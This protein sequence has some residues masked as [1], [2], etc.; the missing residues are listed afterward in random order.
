M[1]TSSQVVVKSNRMIEASYRLSL[2]EQQIIL[3]AICKAREDQK[4]LDSKEP[5]TISANDFST[6]FNANPAVI[7][8]QLKI[9][10]NSL[11]KRLIAI[12]DIYSKKGKESLRKNSYPWLS[13]GSYVDGE[14]LIQLSFNPKIIPYITRLETEFT[15][16]RLEKIGNMSSAHAVRLYELLAQHISIGYREME[17]TWLKE[18]LQL[19][20]QYKAIKD[21]K[22]WVIDVAISQINQHSDITVNYEQKKTGRTITHFIFNMKIKSITP[23]SSK[24]KPAKNPI[25]DRT[26]IE[27][28]ARPGETYEQARNRLIKPLK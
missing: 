18:T 2:I 27:K 19:K 3:F 11:L 5:I 26:Y 12:S 8:G 1:K 6:A 23:K 22:K 7:Y 28:N 25:I 20:D 14:G 10:I 16:Y 15:S 9:A 21:L 17:V 13:Q 4:D 24:S